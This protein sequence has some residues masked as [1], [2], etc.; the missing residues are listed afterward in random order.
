ME[1]K[2]THVL[3]FGNFSLMSHRLSI[4]MMPDTPTGRAAVGA[5]LKSVVTRCNKNINPRFNII[6]LFHFLN[7]C[8]LSTVFSIMTSAKKE[9][10]FTRFLYMYI[11]EDL[12]HSA[13]SLVVSF[14]DLTSF[15][16]RRVRACPAVRLGEFSHDVPF[17]SPWSKKAKQGFFFKC[18]KM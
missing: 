17:F 6:F 4:L 9:L 10:F 1:D 11:S 13:E 12:S 7:F 16:L 18:F 14:S 8:T 2:W 15:S 3:L 5:V